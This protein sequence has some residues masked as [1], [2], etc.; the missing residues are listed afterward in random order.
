V[1]R[2]P[3]VRAVLAGQGQDAAALRVHD[4]GVEY[5]P[6]IWS[7]SRSYRVGRLCSPSGMGEGY[8]ARIRPRGGSALPAFPGDRKRSIP[9]VSRSWLPGLGMAESAPCPDS[10]RILRAGGR[11]KGARSARVAAPQAPLTR[12]CRERIMPGGGQGASAGG[13]GS[14][15]RAGGLSARG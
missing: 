15:V 9:G 4:D 3:A 14:A 13:Y 5:G 8:G 6:S 7:P 1:R 11:V 10:C 2:R 12:L